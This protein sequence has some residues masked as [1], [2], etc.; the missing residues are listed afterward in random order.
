MRAQYQ[1]AARQTDDLEYREYSPAEAAA[2]VLRALEC[3]PC[4]E[5]PDQFE[6]VGSYL[7]LLRSR[8]ELL[9]ATGPGDGVRE[10]PARRPATKG[11]NAT[12]AVAALARDATRPMVHRVKI[13]LRGAKPPIWRRLE[14][15]SDLTLSR[16]RGRLSAGKAV[17]C[18]CPPH[19]RAS[20]AGLTRAWG[21]AARPADRRGRSSGVW[22]PHSLYLRRR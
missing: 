16:S 11:K 9:L 14:L 22:Q 17:T 8:V 10:P 18:G 6:D 19:R 15:P 13:A 2:I 7:G 1:A 21:T 20:S 4:P 3:E 12:S 5:Q